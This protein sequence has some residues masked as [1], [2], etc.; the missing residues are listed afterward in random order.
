MRINSN[1][2]YNTQYNIE[3]NKQVTLY[4]QY[5]TTQYNINIITWYT[6]QSTII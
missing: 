2:L 6:I 1:I 5:N 4:I 3:K